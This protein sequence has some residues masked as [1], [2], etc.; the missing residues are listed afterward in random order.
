MTVLSSILC[1][2]FLLPISVYCQFQP[3][4]NITLGSALSSLNSPSAWT[5]SS[6]DFSF[7]FSTV[8]GSLY[9]GI[10]FEKI[11]RNPL[12]WTANRDSPAPNGSS[13]EFTSNGRLILKDPN[14]VEILEIARSADEGVASA[15]MLDT[16]NFVLQN[17]DGSEFKWQSFDKPTDTILPG[18]V[19][20]AEQQLLSAFSPTNLSTGRFF[21]KMQSD[22]NLVINRLRKPIEDDTVAYSSRTAAGTGGGKLVFNDTGRIYILQPNNSMYDLT[23][24]S[25]IP[26]PADAFYHRATLDY[27]GVFR[28]YI[29]PK[30]SSSTWSQ[31]WNRVWSTTDDPCDVP[32][33]CG[34]NGYCASRGDQKFRCLCPTNY[35]YIDSNYQFMGCKQDFPAPDCRRSPDDYRLA[36]LEGVNWPTG[37]YEMIESVDEGQCRQA[38]LSDCL[39]AVAIYGAQLCWKKKMPLLRGKLSPSPGSKALIKVPKDN[40]SF[41][42]PPIVDGID[43]RDKGREKPSPSSIVGWVFLAASVILNLLLAAGS[44]ICWLHQR[45]PQKLESSSGASEMNLRSFSVMELKEAT[46]FFKEKLGSGSFGSVYKGTL[47]SAEGK[48]IAVKRLDKLMEDGDRIQNRRRTHHKNLVQLL[49]F[50]DEGPNRLLVYEYMEQGSLSST[51]YEST[52]L[53]WKQRILIAS[54]IARGLSYL[55]EECATQIIHCDIKPGNVLLDGNFMPKISDFGLAKLLRHDQTKTLTDNIRGTRGYV[56]PEWFRKMAITVKADVYS[57]GVMLLEIICCRK[58]VELNKRDEESAIL[59]DWAY[60]CFVERQLYKLVERD[61]DASNDMEN[62][63]KMVMV[64]LWCIQEEPS[65]RPTMKKVTQMLEG[66]VKVPVP[67]NPSPF[68]TSM[69]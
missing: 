7:G 64:A 35:S 62:V 19:L 49:G 24:D 53:N 36:T 30:S 54:G 34:V 13:L 68:I 17:S 63:Q 4:R 52:K 39:C 25:A 60:D 44:A 61:Q 16:G 32:S 11:P 18:Q 5:S 22:G 12:V 10:W 9:V 45:R 2:F 55:H 42:F 3:S 26:S 20:K 46:G 27:D 31:S 58:S 69:G 29:F 28:Q 56:A 40:V 15:A 67:P 14:S 48:L 41:I 23:P 33:L 8:A 57:Y 59:V 6:G 21:L 43:R 38:C 51:L 50:C 1:F 37:D 47:N 65:L 66:V